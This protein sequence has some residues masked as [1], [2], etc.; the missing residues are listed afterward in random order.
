[1]TKKQKYICKACPGK[2]PCIHETAQVTRPPS[3]CLYDGN[4]T[5]WSLDQI[6]DEITG[7]AKMFNL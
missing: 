1:M 4:L 2:S 6:E 5:K 7:I 3:R